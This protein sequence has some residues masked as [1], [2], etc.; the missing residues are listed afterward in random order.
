MWTFRLTL[1]PVRGAL[2]MLLITPVAR[3]QGAELDLMLDR[4]V[5]TGTRTEQMMVDSPVR[6]E[7]I[8]RQ[9]IE[10]QHARNLQEALQVL[11]GALLNK[12]HGKTGYEVWLQ[13]IDSNRVLVLID[14]EP[15]SA[16]TGSS[17]DLSQIGSVNIERI[18]VVKGATSALYGS[19]AMG[20]VINIITRQSDQP[21]SYAL[22]GDLGSY[23]DQN[24]NGDPSSHAQRSAAGYLAARHDLWYGN[25]NFDGVDSDGFQPYPSSW[26]QLGPTSQKGTVRGKLGF[27]PSQ[28]QDLFLAAELYDEDTEYRYTEPNPGNPDYRTKREQATRTTY[29]AG[30]TWQGQAF[31]ELS[32]KLFSE[33]FEDTTEQDSAATAFLEQQREAELET[34]K[35]MSQWTLNLGHN[36]RLTSGLDYAEESLSQ[37]RLKRSS[38]TEVEIDSELAGQ[39]PQR[40][41]LELFLQDEIFIGERLRVLPGVR[42]Q[43]DS[44]FGDHVTPK[45]NG[46]Y[47]LGALNSDH[48]NMLRVGI[49]QGYRVPNLKE[50]YYLFDHSEH[51]YV[52]NGNPELQP[53][54]SDSVQLGWVYATPNLFQ[55]EINFYYN[56]LTDLIETG[57]V[58]PASADNDW[59]TQF[60][61]VN[62]AEAETRGGEFSTRI[63]PT[64]NTR[65][66]LAYTYLEAKDLTTG[67]DLGKR[68]RH[69]VKGGIDYNPW[70]PLTLSL[71]GQ[72]QSDAWYDLE[73][74][75]KSPAWSRFDFK[76]N[77]QITRQ[78]K[79][80]GGV[81]NLTD[82]QR[83]FTNSFDLRPDEGRFMYLG[84]QLGND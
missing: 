77:Y 30:G 13:G 63:T 80:Y 28:G 42:Y 65:F 56:K 24:I 55:F 76:L 64:A 5:V 2:L 52:V 20:G 6:T 7:V 71:L 84:L 8:D 12:I 23:G 78:L 18:E 15:V 34:N 38:A 27:T 45:I 29:R 68:P 33:T 41:N 11:P 46:S 35:L 72:W 59:I 22:R 53:E 69:Q 10:R 62:V 17:V 60:A 81:D 47:D 36:H 44:D 61:Y 51:G 37:S 73:N 66:N 58:E 50:R 32:I 48:T 79:L 49:G 39:Q 40:D 16:S 26:D 9:D 54:S 3:L 83:D 31:G 14:G 70:S 67:N 57:L 25:L 75:H 21:L 19:N 82:T 4:V 74:Q 1:R 43:S